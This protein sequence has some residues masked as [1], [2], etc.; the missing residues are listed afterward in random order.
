VKAILTALVLALV[1]PTLA[2]AAPK[3]KVQRITETAADA[4]M[5]PGD[6]YAVPGTPGSFYFPPPGVHPNRAGDCAPLGPGLRDRRGRTLY[7]RFRCTVVAT[8][9]FEG[10]DWRLVF[11]AKARV[12]RDGR[13]ELTIVSTERACSWSPECP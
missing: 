7:A 10:S 9:S 6:W 11:V 8:A 13:G 5:K 12:A 3:P 4:W 1:I 2:T